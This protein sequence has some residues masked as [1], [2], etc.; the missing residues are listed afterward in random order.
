[1][2]KD[3]YFIE[4]DP[5]GPAAALRQRAI[6]QLQEELDRRVAFAATYGGVCYGTSNTV[7]GIA[8]KSGSEPASLPGFKSNG[9][10]YAPDAIYHVFVPDKRTKEG[11]AA[12]KAMGSLPRSKFAELITRE[13]GLYRIVVDGRMGH[14]SH[15]FVLRDRLCVI[16]PWS[17]RDEDGESCRENLKPDCPAGM[18]EVSKSKWVAFTEENAD[19]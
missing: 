5:L 15:A 7:S 11:K 10:E 18:V 17:E 4:S 8:F 16:V 12:A 1:M 2:H 13:L 9:T 19:L 3:A 6:S 14:W